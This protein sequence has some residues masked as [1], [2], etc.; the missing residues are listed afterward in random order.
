MTRSAERSLRAERGRRI[1]DELGGAAHDL[2]GNGVPVAG[3]VV[4]GTMPR[5]MPVVCAA[6]A[7]LAERYP[8]LE[9]VLREHIAAAGAELGGLREGLFDILAV[10]C[11]S[12]EASATPAGTAATCNPDT[13]TPS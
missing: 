11:D 3:P 5:Y 4:I 8:L 1:A 10:V 7:V 9:P 2:A 12:V 13:H 6:V